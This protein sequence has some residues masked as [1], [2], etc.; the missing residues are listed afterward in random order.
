MTEPQVWT[1]IGVFAAA[2][3]GM[4]TFTTQIMWRSINAQFDSFRRE[5]RSEFAAARSE[6]AAHRS[7]TAAQFGSVRSEMEAH[8]SETAAQLESLRVQVSHLDRDVEA[9]SRRVFPK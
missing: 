2:L 3:V 1:L 8:R 4:I 5:M 7:E 9:L 6:L